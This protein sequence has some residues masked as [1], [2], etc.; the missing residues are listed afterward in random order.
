MYQGY[1]PKTHDITLLAAQAGSLHEALT[2]ALPREAAEDERLFQLLRRAYIEARYAKSYRVT[3]EEL[4]V[5]FERVL[6]LSVRV[7]RACLDKLVTIA[8]RG[9]LRELPES[10]SFD[11]GVE[12]PKLVSLDDA[13]AVTEWRDAM[14]LASLERGERLRREGETLGRLQERASAGLRLV[15]PWKSGDAV[16]PFGES[17]VLQGNPAVGVSAADASSAF[18]RRP[19]A[20]APSR[21]T[22][23]ARA[24]GDECS[25]HRRPCA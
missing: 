20:R 10:P 18:R 3:D 15:L 24:R 17:P 14:V 4:E 25:T 11:S 23:P 22:A 9:E 6:D 8:D 13:A 2:G 16:P 21:T 7:R 1:K 5:L 19:L 12:L